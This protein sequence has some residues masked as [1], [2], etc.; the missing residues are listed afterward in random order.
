[1][2]LDTTVLVDLLRGNEAAEARVRDLEEDGELLWIPTPVVFELFEGIERADR[3]EA[4]QERVGQVLS[5]YTLLSFEPAHAREAGR[6]SGQLVRRGRM[7]DPIGVQVAGMALAEDRTVLTRDTADFERV[8]D[9]RV[10]N[11]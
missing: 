4:E 10:A 1:M 6:V 2:I 9:V 11:Y 7:L 5:D 3:P 8:A